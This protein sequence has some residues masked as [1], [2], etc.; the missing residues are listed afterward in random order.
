ME[1]HDPF[2]RGA[3]DGLENLT[4]NPVETSPR[5]EPTAMFYPVFGLVYETLSGSYSDASA[6]TRGNV[7]Q[8][9]LR[10]MRSLVRQEYSGK[11]LLEPTIFEELSSL[12]YRMAMTEPPAV[13]T[14]LIET[15]KAF[16]EGQAGQTDR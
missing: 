3:M 5:S 12:W 16:A 2:I 7:S 11:A 13:Q 9:A 1:Q 4:S 6:N 8:I 15:V 14:H 10:A